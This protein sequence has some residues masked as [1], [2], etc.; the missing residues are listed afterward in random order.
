MSNKV[1]VT[2]ATGFI[3]KHLIHE[4]EH[5]GINHVVFQGDI[6]KN[7]QEW[8]GMQDGTYSDVTHCVH[9]AAKTYVPDSWKN[10][11]AFYQVNCMGTV[12]VLEL[13]K[14]T[15]AKLIYLSTCVYDQSDIPIKEEFTLSTKNPYAHSKRIGEDLCTFYKNE[16]GV[17]VIIMRLFN[18][19]G[20]GQ[21]KEFL[22]SKLVNQVLRG[23]KIEVANLLPRRDYVH[24]DDLIKAILA[25]IHSGIRFGIYNV[26]TGISY[27]VQEVIQILCE[28]IGMDQEV[29]NLNITRSNEQY[30]VIADIS[31]IE[32]DLGW[33]PEISLRE[34]LEKMIRGR[35]G[36]NGSGVL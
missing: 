8:G 20:T 15:G 13:C 28:L 10:A 16:M 14:R 1:L 9:L 32:Q 3:G 25:A 18:I 11:S 12:N 26:G 36:E 30:N 33:R 27:S 17:D 4:L 31:K 34:G 29:V 7:I 22:I 6:Q 35:S 21:R 2:G 23:E 5:Q 24:I 19:Y